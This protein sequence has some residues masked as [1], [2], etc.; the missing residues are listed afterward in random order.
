MWRHAAFEIMREANGVAKIS[1]VE[2]QMGQQTAPAAAWPSARGNREQRSIRNR[3]QLRHHET[4]DGEYMLSLMR[5]VLDLVKD[6]PH[7]RRQTG[8]DKL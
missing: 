4:Q 6:D 3:W 2:E 8:A 5:Q 1:A 7:N